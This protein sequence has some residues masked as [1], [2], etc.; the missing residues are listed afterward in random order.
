M[1]GIRAR[2]RKEVARWGLVS[3]TYSI[4]LLAP[5]VNRSRGTRPTKFHSRLDFASCVNERSSVRVHRG[6]RT[7]V[8][9]RFA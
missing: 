2:S 1:Q 9:R 8:D 4:R 6:A 5:K 7:L 3:A